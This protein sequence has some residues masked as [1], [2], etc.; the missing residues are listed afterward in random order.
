MSCLMIFFLFLQLLQTSQVFV[1]FYIS[2]CA[3]TTSSYTTE[4]PQLD[5]LVIRAGHNDTVI[6]LQAGHAIAM[7]T[8]CDQ[9]LSG[10][11]APHLHTK[12]D[13]KYTGTF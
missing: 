12:H 4:V 3:M 5:C 11:Q 1:L 13:V 9:A 2:Y 8:Q 7:V 6:E 10:L